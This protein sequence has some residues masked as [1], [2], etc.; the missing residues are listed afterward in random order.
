MYHPVLWNIED[1]DYCSSKLKDEIYQAFIKT[2][3]K[4]FDLGNGYQ[5]AEDKNQIYYVCT[6]KMQNMYRKK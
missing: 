3:W 5:A 1:K 2:K 4:S 6:D